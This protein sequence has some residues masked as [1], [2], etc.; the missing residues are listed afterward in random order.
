MKTGIAAMLLCLLS[1]GAIRAQEKVVI[2]G[3]GGLAD[4]MDELAKAYMAKNHS[5]KVEVLKDTM[6]TSG[7]IQALLSGRVTIGLVTSTPKGEEKAKLI[8]RAVGRSPVGV[9]V[10]KSL[11]VNNLSE[12]QICDIFSGKIKSWKEVG[13]DE[14]KITVLTRKQN[15]ANT[16][17]AREKIACFK[18]LK[19]S[20]DAIA[21]LK[22][23]EVLDALNRRP[24]TIGIISATFNTADRPEVKTLAVSGVAP[25][26]EAV[27]AGKYK[28]Y[29]ERGIVMAGPPQGA[30]K[31]FLDFVATPDGQKILVHRGLIPVL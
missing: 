25:T 21:L 16:D 18:D 26:P 28:V 12:T 31:R 19:F 4:E 8:Y 15:D 10:H 30:A 6:G 17:A 13:A 5:D 7:G 24:G 1:A 22:G 3:S 20:P 27:R 9:A 11:A 29:N 2:G 14:A 23:S